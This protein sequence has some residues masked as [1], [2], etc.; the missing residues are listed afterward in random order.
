M[1]WEIAFTV[2]AVGVAAAIVVALIGSVITALQLA[3]FNVLRKAV[4]EDKSDGYFE[5]IVAQL[6]KDG[7][8]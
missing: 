5:D 4:R 1:N 6:T 3:K 8:L 7:D 2:L